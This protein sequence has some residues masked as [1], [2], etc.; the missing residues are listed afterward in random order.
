MAS[1]GAFYKESGGLDVL[2]SYVALDTASNRWHQ[3][4]LV[5]DRRPPA[6]N[7]AVLCRLK[8]GCLLLHGGWKPFVE[9]W[10]DS[11]AMTLQN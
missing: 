11:Y 6:R 2:D 3:V 9:T 5:G 7:A 4:E 8:D 10:N 1:G